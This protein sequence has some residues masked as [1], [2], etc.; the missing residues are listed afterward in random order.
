MKTINGCE[1]LSELFSKLRTP[2]VEPWILPSSGLVNLLGRF[3]TGEI[4]AE[5]LETLADA[6]EMNEAVVYEQSR[7][8]IIADALFVLSNP[9]INEAIT[10]DIV[11]TLIQ[12]LKN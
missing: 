3:L 10:A 6:L 8:E 11:T 5:N 9:A 12:R 7:E 1:E 2:A 4:S